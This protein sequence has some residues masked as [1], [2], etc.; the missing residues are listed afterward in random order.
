M[1]REILALLDRCDRFFSLRADGSSADSISTPSYASGGASAA[2]G[3]EVMVE[4]VTQG[5]A[6]ALVNICFI[7]T[8]GRSP[9]RCLHGKRP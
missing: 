7:F 4:G 9:E 8:S 5:I 2:S 3:C 1:R 6:L